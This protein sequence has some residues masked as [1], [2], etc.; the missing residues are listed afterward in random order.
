MD[1]SW[2]NTYWKHLIR[3]SL[4]SFY[5]LTTHTYFPPKPSIQWTWYFSK[6][7]GPILWLLL[8]THDRQ[9]FMAIF[10]VMLTNDIWSVAIG[11]WRRMVDL[12]IQDEI[13]YLVGSMHTFWVLLLGPHNH[14]QSLNN[15][16]YLMNST[17]LY[18]NTL[19][20]YH[21]YLVLLKIGM[22]C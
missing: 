6:I 1:P 15:V 11:S 7:I 17:Y 20:H 3:P 13:A 21:S 8:K 9:Y 19:H 10:H 16:A 4:S 22:P 5:S 2:S 18:Q 14:R 12:H